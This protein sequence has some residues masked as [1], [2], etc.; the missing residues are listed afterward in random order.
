MIMGGPTHFVSSHTLEMVGVHLWMRRVQTDQP[1]LD[2]FG[3]NGEMA[4]SLAMIP[5]RC[6]KT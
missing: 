1:R 6:C 5:G 2:S 3:S 4:R